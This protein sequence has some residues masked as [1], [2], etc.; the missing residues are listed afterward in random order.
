MDRAARDKL[1]ED[2]LYLPRVVALSLRNHPGVRRMGLEEAVSIGNLALVRAARSESWDPAKG[3]GFDVYAWSAIRHAILNA[4]TDQGPVHVPLYLRQQ[5]HFAP[6]ASS[7]RETVCT[8]HGAEALE[9]AELVGQLLAELPS[10]S[11]AYVEARYLE[12]RDHTE[13]MHE[14]GISRQALFSRQRR[15]MRQM[16]EILTARG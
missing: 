9:A 12:E 13:L 6:L 2:N 16:R 3:S 1:I 14:L 15:A 8:D 5:G 10:T 11:R 4:A 7:L